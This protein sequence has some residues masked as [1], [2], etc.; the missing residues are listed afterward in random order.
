MSFRTVAITVPRKQASWFKKRRC[1]PVTVEVN[2]RSAVYAGVTYLF[3]PLQDGFH[4]VF[5]E[6]RDIPL[7][8]FSPDTIRHTLSENSAKDLRVLRAARYDGKYEVPL[9]LELETGDMV[10]PG[11]C[12][13]RMPGV[14]H[15]KYF[16]APDEEDRCSVCN[17]AFE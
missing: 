15:R 11:P 17:E 9:A 13:A 16:R 3:R 10:H 2:D 7:G 12:L 1:Y 6:G 8:E 4:A 14:I 5:K